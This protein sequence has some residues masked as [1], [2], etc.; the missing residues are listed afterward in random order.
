MLH[1]LSHQGSCLTSVKG[2]SW[3]QKKRGQHHN[4]MGCLSR[5]V[6][7]RCMTSLLCCSYFL[8]WP[9]TMAASM[10][11]DLTWPS[12]TGGWGQD[13]ASWSGGLE[14]NNP[15]RGCIYWQGAGPCTIQVRFPGGASDSAVGQEDPTFGEF[16]RDPLC[17]TP[18]HSGA[19]GSLSP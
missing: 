13:C 11:P 18:H 15:P 2:R 10:H 17:V 4:Q 5:T 6:C 9:W 8:H 7:G 19:A 12:S 16:L 1:L 3:M 14:A